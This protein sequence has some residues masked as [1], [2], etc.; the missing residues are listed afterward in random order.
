VSDFLFR[1]AA[2]ALGSAT[3][4]QPR[5][6]SRFEPA[7]GFEETVEV[8]S[9]REHDA[10][11]AP[12]AARVVPAPVAPALAERV[13]PPALEP[14]PRPP[15][16]VS[17]GERASAAPSAPPPQT[18]P[19]IRVVTVEE[20]REQSET[21]HRERT[22]LEEIVTREDRPATPR[23]PPPP[24]K[25]LELPARRAAARAPSAATERPEPA[26][27]AEVTIGRVEVRAIHQAPPPPREAPARRGPSLTLD[28]YLKQ[29]SGGR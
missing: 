9:A 23:E 6:A 5:L 16:P 27:T 24:R 20:K 26:Q 1:L 8:T 22:I 15:A 4:V 25:P 17:Q 28:D 7:A 2:R 12:E 19:A 11:L 13:P 21:L 3:V 10:A 18:A 14:A 29:R